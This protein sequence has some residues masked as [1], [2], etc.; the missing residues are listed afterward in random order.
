MASGDRESAM[1]KR[2]FYKGK[3]ARDESED[4]N[5]EKSAIS[6]EASDISVD[7]S[8][9][10]PD[11]R[12]NI[13]S[14]SDDGA[15]AEGDGD[16]LERVSDVLDISQPG[17]SGLVQPRVSVLDEPGV[18]GERARGSGTTIMEQSWNKTEEDDG[19]YSI[20]LLLSFF[21]GGIIFFHNVSFF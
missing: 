21:G 1:P 10:D 17:P 6:E 7:Y 4:E 9:Q 11:F 13:S 12:P 14:D 15:R 18:S 19:E 2:L 8:D 5:V 16:N 20:S 3:K